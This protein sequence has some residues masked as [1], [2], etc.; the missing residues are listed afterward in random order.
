MKEFLGSSPSKPEEPSKSEKGGE[1][2][3][4]SVTD[5]GCTA[6]IRPAAES[7]WKEPDK[8]LW[9]Y[10]CKGVQSR[11]KVRTGFHSKEATLLRHRT[12]TI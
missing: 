6:D 3:A 12:V 11:A 10:T 4:A 7:A 8:T 2:S 9:V 1:P 5:S